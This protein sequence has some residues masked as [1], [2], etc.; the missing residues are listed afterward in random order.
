MRV[1]SRLWEARA[2]GSWRLEWGSCCAAPGRTIQRLGKQG[3]SAGVSRVTGTHF[4]GG[5]A[6]RGRTLV[7]E[8][9][10]ISARLMPFRNLVPER[11]F[12]G[13][14][15]VRHRVGTQVTRGEEMNEPLTTRLALTVNTIDTLSSV[16]ERQCHVVILNLVPR[17]HADSPDFCSSFSSSPSRG[18]GPARALIRLFFPGDQ[19]A[20]SYLQPLR[21]SNSAAHL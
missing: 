4:P 7:L 1:L 21:G 6:V 18:L 2:S 5:G 17:G 12:P 3:S 11:E 10:Y 19:Y 9:S 15:D 13:G 20:H 8:L 14:R 16:P